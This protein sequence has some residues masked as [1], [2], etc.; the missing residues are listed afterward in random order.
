MRA[1]S[2]PRSALVVQG[3]RVQAAVDTSL[4]HDELDHFRLP[5]VVRLLPGTRRVESRLF[6]AFVE[7]DVVRMLSQPVAQD[8]LADMVPGVRLEEVSDPGE[9][10][11]LI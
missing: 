3:D 6:G 4:F 10:V 5:G 1:F 9:N 8:P 7:D 11:N 2:H